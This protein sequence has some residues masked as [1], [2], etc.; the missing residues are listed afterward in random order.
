MKNKNGVST[1]TVTTL[2][3][4][5]ENNRG[6]S[7]AANFGIRYLNASEVESLKKAGVEILLY[8]NWMNSQS[9]VAQSKCGRTLDDDLA[10]RNGGPGIR[11]D[12]SAFFPVRLTNGVPVAVLD[13]AK[14]A[15]IYRAFGIDYPGN[16]DELSSQVDYYSKGGVPR[17][18][19]F[20]LGRSS[21]LTGS[22][23][24]NPP[25]DNYLDKVYYRNYILVFKML[26]GTGNAGTTVSFAGVIDAEGNCASQAIYNMDWA[27]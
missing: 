4:A 15:N 3:E 18:V 5:R 17:L 20:G 6:L 16:T 8:H 9:T 23:F 12:M 21:D 22:L 19:C 10:T 14:S 26:N 2:E 7:C 24:E 27:N 13:P 25:R 11:P 1:G